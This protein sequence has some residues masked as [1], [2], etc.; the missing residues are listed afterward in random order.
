LQKNEQAKIQERLQDKVDEGLEVTRN[1]TELR[2]FT[3]PF[4]ALQI[5]DT[6]DKGKGVFTTR[7]FQKGEFVCEYT[8]KLTTKKDAIEQ[9]KH[10]L[11]KPATGC[12]MYYFV[13]KEKR[14]W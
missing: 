3:F 4:F 8:G 5:R 10:Y 6:L 11:E 7:F 13:H 2:I 9:E 1:L 12:Y 14:W